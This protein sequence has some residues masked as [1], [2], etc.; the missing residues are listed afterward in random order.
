[1][2]KIILT[3]IILF[4]G[5]AYFTKPDD[6]TC[7]IEGTRAVWGDL[8]PDVYKRPDMFESFMNL[9]SPS[10]QVKDWIFFKQV[11]YK[12]PQGQQTVA[13]GAFKK[14]YPTVKPIER[15]SY[16]PKLP[17]QSKK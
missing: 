6:K 13:Y 7:I 2:G 3:L 11:K 4:L 8:M 16:I 15:D 10:V 5:V 9:N 14:V 12:V 17:A 1:M